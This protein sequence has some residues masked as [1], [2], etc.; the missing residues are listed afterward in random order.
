[1]KHSMI[2]MHAKNHG[3][4]CISCSDTEAFVSNF[5]LF[6][7]GTSEPHSSQ[8]IGHG[9]LISGFH[10]DFSWASQDVKLE[11]S[12]SNGYDLC[13]VNRWPHLSR[14]EKKRKKFVKIR[15]NPG[16]ATS[17]QELMNHS[18]INRHAE[19]YGKQSISF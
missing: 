2:N 15:K 18:M 16:G 5:S 14:P 3:D 17:Q 9:D 4:Q 6:W 12:G 1:M 19:N 10:G 11:D 7:G 8:N 13:P